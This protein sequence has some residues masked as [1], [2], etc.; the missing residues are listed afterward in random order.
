MFLK[1]PCASSRTKK[2]VPFQMALLS[3]DF[4][5]LPP[6][7]MM[8]IFNH[9]I[10]G[11]TDNDKGTLSFWRSF[12]EYDICMN[13]HVQSLGV[14]GTKS[15]DGSIFF[16]FVAGVIPTQKEKTQEDDKLYRLWFIVDLTGSVYSAFCGCQ[17][18]ADQGCRHLGEFSFELDDFLNSNQRKYITSM[19]AYWDP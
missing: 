19:S 12:K 3:N 7:E 15:L 13:G 2:F 10:M 17:G 6:I 11:K 14:N 8:D 18:G 4:S 16:L 5:Q 1:R 9:L